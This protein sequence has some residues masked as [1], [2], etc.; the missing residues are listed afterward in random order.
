MSSKALWTIPLAEVPRNM[1]IHQ[2]I[3][4]TTDLLDQIKKFSDFD[5]ANYRKAKIHFDLEKLKQS[6]LDGVDKFGLHQFQYGGHSVSNDGPYLSS[7]LT[8]NPSAYDKISSDPHLATLGS[9][10]LKW[11]SASHYDDIEGDNGN[12]LYR[13]SY[14]D[15][16]AFCER[17]PFS[18]YEDLDLFLN[19]FDRTL[20]RSRV[21]SII[22]KKEESRKFGF[23]WHNDELV[24]INLRINVP[25]QTSPNY[26]IQIIKNEKSDVLDMD[27]FSME[28][29]S[30]YVYDTSKN[31]RPFCKKFDSIDRLHM[32]C[33]V[34]PWFD[35]DQKTQ[36]W[37]S[38]EF[39]GE[40][41]P[42]EMFSK[43]LISPL[44]SQ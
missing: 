44:I 1:A 24:F 12:R 32:I 41:H 26:V 28:I 10:T 29:G 5:S 14:H 35:F 8:Y 15:T 22:A 23:G 18:K 25:I 42:F 36:C 31:H 3:I 4:K 20:I 16:Y 34:S 43:G 11:N 13:N 2:Y 40:V 21:S 33:G 38:N 27:E 7:S 9:T 19:S 17:T 39:Y 6:A 30:A 37:I